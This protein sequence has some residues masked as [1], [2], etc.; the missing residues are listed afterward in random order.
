[1]AVIAR[2]RDLHDPDRFVWLRGL[3]DMPS[4]AEALGRFYGGP[5]WKTHKDQANATMID[6][7]DVLL[8]RPVAP[9]RVS[10]PPVTCGS[11]L[12]IPH[13]RR[14]PSWPRCTTATTR[15]IRRGSPRPSVGDLGD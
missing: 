9:L 7:D 3:A 15:S 13:R 8:L 2:F 10:L 1:M 4:R 14:P 6:S 11:R 12:A 5:V